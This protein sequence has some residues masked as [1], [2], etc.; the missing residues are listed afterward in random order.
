MSFS[1]V[2]G[3]NID[4]LFG[5]L[6]AI[7]GIN[8]VHS[9]N[10]ILA[11][12]EDFDVWSHQLAEVLIGSDHISKETLLLCLM[13]EGADDIIGLVALDFKDGYAVGL[14]DTFDIRH[15]NEDALGRLLAIGLVELVTLVPEG[16]ASR[17][18][19]AHSDV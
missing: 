16:F 12:I 4:K 15:G 19:K 8:L 18:V 6:Y 2:L 1:A 13:G 7:F 11:G 14:E 3:Q 17:R 5:G 9:Q 10:L